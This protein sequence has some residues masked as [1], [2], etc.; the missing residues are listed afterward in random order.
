MMAAPVG[1]TAAAPLPSR[2]S[3]GA[4]LSTGGV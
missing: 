3:F 2:R 4:V 1:V